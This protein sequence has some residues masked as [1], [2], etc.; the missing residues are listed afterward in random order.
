VD[1]VGGIPGLLLPPPSCYFALPLR[2]G[3]FYLTLLASLRYHNRSADQLL[4][5]L[6]AILFFGDFDNF[7]HPELPAL[8]PV[9]TV[10][11]VITTFSGALASAPVRKRFCSPRTPRLSS[12]LIAYRRAAATGEDCPDGFTFCF[13][14][15]AIERLT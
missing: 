8:Q 10:L 7:L 12:F 15:R 6:T 3:G 4:S 2:L 11:P 9:L 5:E 14:G 13:G 1:D